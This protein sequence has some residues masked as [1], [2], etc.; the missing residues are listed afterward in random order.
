MVG[1]ARVVLDC[2]GPSHDIGVAVAEV[3]FTSSYCPAFGLSTV[4]GPRCSMISIL[5][6]GHAGLCEDWHAL[7]RLPDA[8]QSDS[9]CRRCLCSVS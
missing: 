9:A 4:V 6:F 3:G 5:S 8:F 7:D 2:T 1:T